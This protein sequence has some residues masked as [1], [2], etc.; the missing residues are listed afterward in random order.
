VFEVELLDI[1]KER[2]ASF[3]AETFRD[4]V[5]GRRRGVVS[6]L[7]RGALAAGE[8]LYGYVIRR[9][10]RQYDRGALPITRVDAPVISVGN[11]T[12]GGTGKTP[13]VVWLAKWFGDQGQ[14][15]SLLSRGYGRA[16]ANP[17]SP[18]ANDEALE[19]ADLL[20][21][22]PHRQHPD[23]I[24]A[25]RA[26]LA[27]N[28]PRVLILDDAFQ[29]RR[30]AR[31]LD[32]VLLDA[33]APFGYGHLLPRGLLREPVESLARAQVIALSR[34]DAI[35][36]ERRV[37]IQTLVQQHAP[38]AAWLE[39]VHRPVALRDS[40]GKVEPLDGWRGK[41]VAAFAGIGNPAGFRHTLER[42]GLNIIELR[43][44]A[45]H[46]AFT[47]QVI[48]SLTT[49]IRSLDQ[50]EGVVCTHKDLVKVQASELAGLPLRALQIEMSIVVG[51]EQLEGRLRAVQA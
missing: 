40:Q 32:I 23:R 30:I 4:I 38:D 42:A 28:G 8:P 50:A 17:A 10:N 27:A 34:S 5:S 48:A 14:A 24:A 1:V 2:V 12:V 46:Q 29:H 35:S 20:P 51:Q 43:A 19:I 25:A 49:W 16:A 9:K 36:A 6:S 39:L 15:V 37:E 7:V 26:E 44:L 13:F 11:L 41:R 31:D 22:V 18:S 21:D 3:S 33:L 45:D 47:P